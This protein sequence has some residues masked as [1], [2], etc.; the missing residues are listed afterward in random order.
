M[1]VADLARRALRRAAW[2]VKKL[3]VERR[4]A[5]IAPMP[6]DRSDGVILFFTPEAGVRA[7]LAAQCVVAKTLQAR[8]NR[9]LF[10]RCF[11]LFQRCPVMDMY[12]FPYVHSAEEVHDICLR[13]G[14]ASI[15]M[16]DAY[17]FEHVDLR[18][19]AT[20][21]LL[22]R[23]RETLRNAPSDLRD[24]VFDG[25][26]FGRIGVMELV[27]AT[28]VSMFDDV[29]DATRTA[30]LQYIE[31][32]L[33][34]YLLVDRLL[35]L[36]SVNRMVHYEDYT[37]LI[38][39]R[40][41]AARRRVP[42]ITLSQASH[43]NI[44]RRRYILSSY[45]G[46]SLDMASI[47]AWP[48]WR[49]LALT[50][51][52][53]HDVADDLV[54]RLRGGGSHQFSP[55][56]TFNRTDIRDDLKLA[57]NRRLLVAYTSSLDEMIAEE[58]RLEA[59]GLVRPVR[60]ETFADQFEWLEALIAHVESSDDLQLVVRVHPREGSG[61]R[62]GTSQHLGRLQHQFGRSFAHCQ[63]IWPDDP[64]S[65]FDL[66]EA[67]DLALISWSTIGVELARLGVPVL[68]STVGIGS[69]PHDDFIEW[70]ADHASYFAELRRL[71]GQPARLDTVARAFRWYH[72]AQLGLALDLGDVV[73]S[74][75]FTRLPPFKVPREADAIVQA[76]LGGTPAA[77]L[78]LQ[79]QVD[80]QG[81][82]SGAAER[83][84]L[85]RELRRLL[86]FLCT[87][88]DSPGTAPLAIRVNDDT[89][90]YAAG[91]RT[92]TRY[93]PLCARLAPLCAS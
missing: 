14:S 18:H 86:H 45:A 85:Q 2:S 47:A 63:F 42:S 8:G 37:L 90:S 5:V 87:G 43:N 54:T 92:I 31:S 27:L 29:D 22:E 89:I 15:D 79:R 32:G 59:H 74:T 17:G 72:L 75:D 24:F 46:A 71:I 84:A 38:G 49:E 34:A 69:Y 51:A 19:V 4:I 83:Q 65:S 93:S 9:V 57:K 67:A 64:T 81:A 25:I 33:M 56:K 78:N 30:W 20:P 23:V 55:A 77:A 35:R 48:A 16:L 26:P 52:Q 70:R 41:A 39:A 80:A 61:V 1:G 3:D 7:H 91:G 62:A 36:H 58:M 6:Q 88:Q 12:E 44:D 60:E 13:C 10:V 40:L 73:P 53:V 50:G 11:K 21:E 28:K 68:A 76:V 82:T 66:A